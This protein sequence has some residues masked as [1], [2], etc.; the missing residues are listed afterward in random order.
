MGREAHATAGQEAG[1]TSSCGELSMP[2]GAKQAAEK[3]LGMV[4]TPETHTSGPKGHI[5]FAAFSAR[6]KSCPDTKRLVKHVL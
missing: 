5:D 2:S 6:L 1:A 3:G 4:R